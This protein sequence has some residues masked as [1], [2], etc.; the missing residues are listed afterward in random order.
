LRALS[1]TIDTSSPSIKNQPD[2][3]K[4]VDRYRCGKKY[5]S[6]LNEVEIK[7]HGYQNMSY[8]Q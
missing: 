3:H 5:F 7:G 1:T 2:V 6:L 8:R 4:M